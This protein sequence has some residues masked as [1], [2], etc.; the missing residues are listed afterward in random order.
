MGWFTVKLIVSAA[1]ISFVSWLSGRK[2][3]LAGLL[4]A[5]PLVTLLAFPFSY[6]EHK[7]LSKAVIFAKST[8][9]AVPISLVF[10]LPFVLLSK[11]KFGF[12]GLYGT[13]VVLLLIGVWF[14]QRWF[15]T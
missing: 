3:G 2:P 12:W 14:H 4:L 15:P 1:L 11:E 13:G 8:L 9:V 6:L 7:D 10:F 5:L